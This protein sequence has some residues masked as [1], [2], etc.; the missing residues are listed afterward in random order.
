VPV[1]QTD[2]HPTRHVCIHGHF[3][4]P[5]RENPWLQEIEIQESAHPWHD[6]NQRVAAECYTPNAH[7]RILDAEGRLTD[8]INNYQYISF[9][10]GPTL[11]S[12]MEKHAPETYQ[13]IRD[14]D[15]LSRAA[16]SGHGNAIAQAYNHMIMPLASTRDKITQVIWGL[17]DFR[18][19]FG[20][21]PEGMWLPEAAVDTETLDI[22]SRH[23]IRFTILAP[24]QARR[25]RVHPTYK[26][27]TLKH[28]SID[29]SRPYLCTLPGGRTVTL[30][31]YDGPISRAI[32]FERLLDNGDGLTNRLLSRF[33]KDKPWNQIVHVAT[34]GESYGHHHRFGEMALAYAIYRLTKDPQVRLT[35]YGE[36]LEANPAAA[37]VEI[38]EKS[39]WSCSHGLGRWSDDCGCCLQPRP[40]WNQ[41]WRAPLRKALDLVRDSVDRIFE[42]ESSSLLKDPWEGRNA[43]VDVILT[44]YES[45]PEF[46]TA[47]S[48]HP[49]LQETDRGRI[50]TLL[51]M[52][53]HRMLMYTSCGW[54]FDDISGIEALQI[55]KY[56]SRV[57]QLA[58]HF[59]PALEASFRAELAQ[60]RSNRRLHPTA[61]EI[62]EQRVIPEIADAAK[63]A[64]HVAISSLFDDLADESR[65]YCYRIKL[66]DP[67]KEQSGERVLMIRRMQ[68]GSSVAMES[69]DL[70]TAT[71]YLGGVDVRCSV[72]PFEERSAYELMTKD[73]LASFS[74]YSS[75]ELIRKLDL[76]FPG[77]YFSLWD[78]FA[79]QRLRIIQTITR[80]MYEEQAVLFE[81]FYK[82]NKALAMLIRED[83]AL[84]PDTLLASARFVVNRALQ[85]ELDKISYGSFP[86][87]L[88][89]ILEEAALWKMQLD[90]SSVEKL[91]GSR[92]LELIGQLEKPALDDSI[93]KEIMKFLDLCSDLEL[94]PHLGDAQILLFRMIRSIQTEKGAELPR[95]FQELARRLAVRPALEKPSRDQSFTLQ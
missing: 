82:K 33:S 11:L 52:Q 40:G 92:I 81:T 8:I 19:R 80:K 36:F 75:T 17:A 87:R 84:L 91:I 43:Y 69:E 79:E 74:T 64:A 65:L 49:R 41:K 83:D 62:F 29:P 18:K 31:F 56:A 32:A 20:R 5:P 73:L 77:H 4:Q 35:N 1:D 85:T 94:S 67:V 71:L 45:F 37:E 34:D 42:R 27:A 60:A 58:S 48:V 51:E 16:R 3:Y 61:A 30:F 90:I 28:E 66:E 72:K 44:N 22:L 70:I 93:P 50:L 38:V 59:E 23:G 14:A 57:L 9:N 54:F 53:R 89:T 24:H 88:E 95:H 15:A 10:F 47:H 63:V 6:W 25:F 55:L 7:A 78:L 12:W 68:V 21:D 2:S 46:L 76:H 13:A 86:D 39:S 26:W